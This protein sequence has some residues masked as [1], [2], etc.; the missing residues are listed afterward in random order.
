MRPVP[1]ER[2]RADPSDRGRVRDAIREILGVGVT[3]IVVKRGAEGATYHDAESAIHA[4]AFTAEEVDPTGAG[5]CFG[6]TFV[7]CRLQG[8]SAEE[9]LRYASA[10][11]AR[12]VGIKGPMEGTS[13]FAELEQLIRTVEA[14]G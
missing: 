1:A 10:S 13:T 3:A 5:D 14:G 4:R 2:A 11:G 12:A 8:R 9:A 6:A 7:T